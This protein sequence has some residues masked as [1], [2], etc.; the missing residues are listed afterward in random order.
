MQLLN[1]LNLP[2]LKKKSVLRDLEFLA[3]GCFTKDSTL[4]SE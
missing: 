1:P 4:I 3:R 2:Y